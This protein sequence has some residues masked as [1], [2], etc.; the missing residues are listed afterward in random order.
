MLLDA[1]GYRSQFDR[2]SHPLLSPHEAVVLKRKVTLAEAEQPYR[3]EMNLKF[4]WRSFI[5]RGADR[6]I[7][8]VGR[9]PRVISSEQTSA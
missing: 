8:Q 6:R 9:R 5:R 1:D 4:E 2:L 7:V 3:P